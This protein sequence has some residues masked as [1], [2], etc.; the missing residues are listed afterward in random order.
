MLSQSYEPLC[1]TSPQKAVVLLL[2]MKAEMIATDGERVIHSV[3]RAYPF[4]SVIRLLAYIKRPLRHIEPGR[5]NILKRDG[6]KCQY[7]G[8]KGLQLTVDHVIPK[9]RG[10]Q[11]TWENLTTAC[12]HCNNIKGNRTP[13]EAGMKLLTK[14]KAPS[15]LFF[16]RQQIGSREDPWRPFL[17]M[18]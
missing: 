11:D 5:K 13:E 18:D 6:M 17:F 3:S 9:S 4:P 8:R 10:G 12:V 14:P 2:L 1:I 16:L 15:Y 7:C